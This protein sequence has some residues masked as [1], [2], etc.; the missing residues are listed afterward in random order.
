METSRKK[1]IVA[2]FFLG[3]AISMTI[4]FFA[5]SYNRSIYT[6][7]IYHYSDN[8]LWYVLCLIFP[9]IIAFLFTYLT[10]IDRIVSRFRGLLLIFGILTTLLFITSVTFNKIYWGYSFIR[11]T[12]FREIDNAIKIKNISLVHN[13]GNNPLSLRNYDYKLTS[14]LYGRNDPYYGEKDRIFMNFQDNLNNTHQLSKFPEIFKDELLNITND[15]L[16]KISDL[17]YETKIVDM[18]TMGWD[19]SGKLNGIITE[20][21]S[22][23]NETFYFASLNGGQVSNDHWPNYEFLLKETNDNIIL[24]KKQRFYTDVAGIEG[25]E[26]ANLYPILFGLFS[27]IILIII[28]SLSLV[29]LVLMKFG[30]KSTSANN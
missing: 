27:Q 29:K 1:T 8:N 19:T 22:N 30:Q 28:S 15:K 26:F 10:F 11:P 21:M 17:I 20:F 23:N 12:L 4:L 14:N 25:L 16:Q 5:V 24:L 7:L 9:L 18:G 13:D 6:K 3:Y 2:K